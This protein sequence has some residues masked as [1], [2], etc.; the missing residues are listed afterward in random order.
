MQLFDTATE[1][2]ATLT[3]RDGR[4]GMYVCGLTPYAGGHL[5]HAFTYH[6]FDVIARRLWADGVDV[7]SVRNVTD[8]D[9]DILRVARERGIDYRVLGDRE[10]LR[11]DRDMADLGLL[12]VDAAPRATNR[13]PE[14]VDWINRLIAR[15]S[16]YEVQGWV[17]FDVARF[18]RYGAFSGLDTVS[19]VALSRERGGDP[20]DARKRDPLDFVLWQP[21]LPDEP[22]WPSPWSSGRPGWHIECTVMAAAE[23]P[24]PVDIHGGGD[25][26]IFPHHESEIAQ[27]VAGGVRSYVRH[28][29]HVAMVGYQGEKM[30]KS[31]GNLVFVR[32][33]L[34][35]VPAAV[36]R[37]LLCAHHHR[38]AWEYDEAELDRAQARWLSYQTALGS[39]AMFTATDAQA[40]YDDF[41]TCIDDDL[42]T[43]GALVILDEVAGRPT[44]PRRT[45]GADVS[46]AQLIG[47]LLDVIGVPIAGL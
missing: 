2:L 16:A 38:V 46:A 40:V 36:I 41:M 7:R 8:V 3:P 20:D 9:D 26:L 12:D 25:D 24:L 31:L 1:A 6:T 4:V 33:L 17:Y 44:L 34:D 27:A 28:W 47:P 21:S 32:D 13:V 11:F 5:G 15:G 42:D 39:E 22:R 19:M 23:L 14:M 10:T 29:V 37:L 45:T 35:R 30:S 43:P 18:P